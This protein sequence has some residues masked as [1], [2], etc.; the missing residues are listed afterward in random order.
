[1]DV[2]EISVYRGIKTSQIGGLT[3][4]D[5]LYLRMGIDSSPPGVSSVF[6]QGLRILHLVT[7]LNRRNALMVLKGS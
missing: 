1:M 4:R 7:V 6:D 5:T 2:A 3:I